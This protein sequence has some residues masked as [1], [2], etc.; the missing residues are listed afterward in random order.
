MVRNTNIHIFNNYYHA[1]SAPYK[2]DYAIGIRYQAKVY[3]E[4]NYFSSGIKYSYSG[5]DSKHGTLWVVGDADESSKNGKGSDSYVIAT[6]APFTP[7]YTWTAE[8]TTNLPTSIP[9]SA[10]AGA[11]LSEE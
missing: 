7:S 3:S 10:G 9:S 6:E 4:K 8:D 5:N 2:Q 11:V 1:S